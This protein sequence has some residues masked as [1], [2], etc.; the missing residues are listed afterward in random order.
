MLRCSV[1]RR[2]ADAAEVERAFARLDEGPGIYFGSDAGIAGLHPLGA[3]L[4]DAP[5]LAF[6]VFA[7]G[8]EVEPLDRMGEALLAHPSL[9]AFLA[10][11]G[12]GPGRAPLPVLRAF[13]ASLEPIAEVLLVGAVGFEAHRLAASSTASSA[14]RGKRLGIFYFAPSLLRRDAAGRWQRL[15]LQFADPLLADAMSAEDAEPRERAASSSSLGQS[16]LQPQAP[17]TMP[18]D[19]FA[20]GAYAAVV[21][22]AIAELNAPGLLAD[23][24]P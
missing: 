15:T 20:P 6:P 7:D 24:Q 4:L 12:Q 17:G 3:T 9:A 19:D 14:L 11:C 16:A 21:A 23:P 18:Q 22:R 5:A 1:A 10:R 13:L 8:L 2:D